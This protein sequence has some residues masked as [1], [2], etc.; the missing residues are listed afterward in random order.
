[1]AK[2]GELEY[3][4]CE[5]PERLNTGDLSFMMHWNAYCEQGVFVDFVWCVY[6]WGAEW[7]ERA[8]T[9]EQMNMV[10]GIWPE[11]Q[12]ERP[13]LSF[14]LSTRYPLWWTQGGGDR[15]RS[16]LPGWLFVGVEVH[17][18]VLVQLGKLL[19]AKLCWSSVGTRWDM[20]L[21]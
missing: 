14:P 8:H 12:F 5:N 10:T 19:E 4:S 15:E 1:M 6:G 16:G 18:L 3:L 7:G 20:V 9:N 21:P 11:A 2:V 13:F 17:V